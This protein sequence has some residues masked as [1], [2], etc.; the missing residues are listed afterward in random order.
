MFNSGAGRKK[1]VLIAD[2]L[3][4]NIFESSYEESMIRKAPARRKDC[5]QRK[6][7]VHLNSGTFLPKKLAREGN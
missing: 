5:L 7:I 2:L 4:G 3:F 1:L 6:G